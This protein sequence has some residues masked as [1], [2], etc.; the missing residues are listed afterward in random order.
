MAGVG[1]GEKSRRPRRCAR[2]RTHS[3]TASIRRGGL[4]GT[5]DEG[6]G[7]GATGAM[8]GSEASDHA[9]L[10]ELVRVADHLFTAVA[11]EATR[12][13]M[14]SSDD[15]I[16]RP[17]AEALLTTLSRKLVATPLILPSTTP[18]SSSS[19]TSTTPGSACEAAGWAD[20]D[21]R[22]ALRRMV[23]ALVR[24]C[25]HGRTAVSWEGG[26]GGSSRLGRL[27]VVGREGGGRS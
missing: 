3:P 15:G 27:E 8:P 20:D 24:A 13:S 1:G 11:P 18:T 25:L 6:E 7:N 22:V 10:V 14:W 16:D 21:Q 23:T 5:E 9:C 4:P 26:R 19:A 2:Q 12:H 17:A